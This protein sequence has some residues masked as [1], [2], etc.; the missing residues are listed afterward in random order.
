MGYDIF[1]RNWWK[2]N[3]DWPEGLEPDGTDKKYLAYGIK[4]R[5]EA[6]EICQ[7]YNTT[8]KP[9]RLSR[10]AEFESDGVDTTYNGF[11]NRNTWLVDLW[12]DEQR[13]LYELKQQ[14]LKNIDRP[15][16]RSDVLEF[17]NDWFHVEDTGGDLNSYSLT[18]VDWK[19]LTRH[20]ESERQEILAYT[21]SQLAK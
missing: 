6:I 8:H 14:L 5:E 16:L 17:V 20:W 19:D 12:I 11:A 10:K 1:V 2:E 9:G 4:T 7:E 13:H 21:V 18:T 3:P 15:V